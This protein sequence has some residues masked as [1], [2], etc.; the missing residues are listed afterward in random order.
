M[1]TLHQRPLHSTLARVAVAGAASLATV[2]ATAPAALADPVDDLA[3]ADSSSDTTSDDAEPEASPTDESP[4][5]DQPDSGEPAVDE[6]DSAAFEAPAQ[7]DALA[8]TAEAGTADDE[9][10][11]VQAPAIEAQYGLQKFRVGVKF[12]PGA[13]T[14]G[15]TTAGS[16]FRIQISPSSP[17]DDEPSF[18]PFE[19]EDFMCTTVEPTEPDPEG[20]TYC[21][22]D[23]G[24]VSA[25]SLARA[26]S[27]SLVPES[28]IPEE[29]AFIAPPGSTVTVTQ[30]TAAEGFDATAAPVVIEP[31]TNLTDV[32]ISI[33]VCGSGNVFDLDF[34][35]EASTALFVNDLTPEPAP[36][37]DPVGNDTDPVVDDTDLTTVAPTD[38]TL[39]DTGGTD[40]RLLGLGGLLLA[41]GSA[42][43][44]AARRRRD[45]LVP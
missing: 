13:A 2:L 43:A 36:D 12:A 37:P 23:E 24:E 19:G 34:S 41:S 30:L 20:T 22:G 29:Q 14:D 8:P 16:T 18:P 38:A 11:D 39:P 40:A 33:P 31:C 26:S 44:V 7:S 28:D 27:G 25:E 4:A 17:T 5:E 42:L 15:Q 21:E 6:Q 45:V 10:A 3:P 35:L 9:A 32:P 1:T